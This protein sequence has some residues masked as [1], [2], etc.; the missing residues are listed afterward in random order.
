MIK[1]F[2]MNLCNITSKEAT[3]FINKYG[4]DGKITVEDVIFISHF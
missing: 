4:K 2:K 3:L 1:A